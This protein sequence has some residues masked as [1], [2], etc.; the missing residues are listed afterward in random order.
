MASDALQPNQPLDSTLRLSERRRVRRDRCW[1][2]RS[3]LAVRGAISDMNVLAPLAFIAWLPLTQL[4]FVTIRGHRAVAFLMVMGWLFL[5]AASF[6]IGGLPDISKAVVV[7]VVTALMALSTEFSRFRELRFRWFDLPAVG[8]VL[9]MIPASLTNGLGIYDGLSGALERFLIWGV[10]YILGRAYFTTRESFQDLAMTLF[11][12]GLCY[13]PLCLIEIRMSPMLCEW[14][15]DFRPRRLNGFRFGGWRPTVFLE[16]GLELGMFM[17]ISSLVGFA[18]YIAKP[19]DQIRNISV[20]AWLTLLGVTTVLCKSSGALALLIVGFVAIQLYRRNRS[21]AILLA[22]LLLFVPPVYVGLRT[23]NVWNGSSAVSVVGRYLSRDRAQ[24]LAYRF[25]CEDVLMKKAFTRPIF[26]W[27][28]HGRSRVKD[29][30]GED[31]VETDGLWIIHFGTTGVIGLASTFSLL[32]LPVGLTAYRFRRL[33][34]SASETPRGA[35]RSSDKL[36]LFVFVLALV[37]ALYAIDG[38]FNWFYSPVYVL[39]A[40][41][42]QNDVLKSFEGRALCRS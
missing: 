23:A 34:S 12:G 7:N 36:N 16:E 31:I 17:T 40:G 21:S 9:C 27:A 5:P 35:R 37:V 11:I 18:V 24:S 3:T 10:P 25:H 42:L 38:L 30:T 41:A 28:G 29:A 32:L 8:I 19:Q 6:E 14:I 4:V 26:G 13:I 33:A 2:Y 20:A 15:Y 39:A 22:M 1:K